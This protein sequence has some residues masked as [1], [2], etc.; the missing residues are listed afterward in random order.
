MGRK[1]G[2]EGQGRGIGEERGPTSKARGERREEGGIS[3]QNL[4][5]KLRPCR[6]TTCRPIY[7]GVIYIPA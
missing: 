7:G 3:P 4:K 6:G 2:K 5:N 1:G